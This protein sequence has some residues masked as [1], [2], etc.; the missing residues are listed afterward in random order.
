MHVGPV[1]KR[2]WPFFY[3]T[4]RAGHRQ[5]WRPGAASFALGAAAARVHLDAVTEYWALAEHG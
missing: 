3:G 5:N 2:T 1:V 4:G